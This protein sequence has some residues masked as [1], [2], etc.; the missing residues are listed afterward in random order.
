MKNINKLIISISVSIYMSGCSTITNPLDPNSR[1]YKPNKI[2]QYQTESNLMVREIE[3]LI[4][5]NQY[6]DAAQKLSELS[7][8]G[9]DVKIL[10][11]L[12]DKIKK[13]YLLN[14]LFNELNKEENSTDDEKK[15][16]IIESILKIEPDNERAYKLKKDINTKYTNY[17]VEEPELDLALQARI[18]LEFK[19]APLQ[20]VLEVLSQTSGINF[21]FDKDLNVSS[22]N[23]TIFA[24]NT[25]I[26]EAL[27][28]IIRTG[29]V[30]YKIL[31]NNTFL[32]YDNKDEKKNIY[33]E[34]ITRSFFLNAASADKVQE[35]ITKLYTPKSIFADEKQKLLVVRDKRGVIDSIE[36]LI[37]V[38]DTDTP[39]VLLDI[40]VLEVARDDLLN[41]GVDFP[42]SA[43]LSLVNGSNIL[44]SLTYEQLKNINK[45]NFLLNLSDPLAT[46]NLRET[47]NN[48]NLLANPRI[49]IKS[50]E[51]A[52]FL[53]GDKVPVI[54]TSTGESGRF[55][56]ESISYLDVGLKIDA[57][58]T[59]TPN[60]NID[61][62]I[63]LEV[64]NIV[65]EV[66]SKNGLVAYQIGTRN[67]STKLQLRNGETQMLAG[68]IKEEKQQSANHLPGIGRI[69]FLGRLFSNTTDTKKKSEIV[70]LITPHLVKPFNKPE[71][72][73]L[74]YI[75]GS[76]SE[77][78]S[79]PLRLTN[80]SNYQNS[81]LNLS[82]EKDQVQINNFSSEYGFDLRGSSNLL[83][84]QSSNFILSHG[85][86]NYSKLEI[87]YEIPNEFIVDELNPLGEIISVNLD[88]NIH[89]IS[90][91]PKVNNVSGDILSLKL[92]VPQNLS[93][94][95][96]KF[97]ITKIIIY[98]DNKEEEHEVKFVK[99][100]K[101][102]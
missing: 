19:N 33:D 41:L 36:K 66:Q 54:T 9:V 5:N 18:S 30:N 59:V 78:T 13:S 80:Q 100:F 87:F 22:V 65:K 1:S 25:T 70:L 45:A 10:A 52:N 64:S 71:Y 46:I 35:M 40:E 14:I 57:L 42:N 101:V 29:G 20:S 15:L 26:K 60:N 44:K 92:K 48:S 34:L 38:V 76:I 86:I 94:D 72:E 81:S 69:P 32:I 37:K 99:E 90:V 17:S 23:T 55:L 50:K 89:S 3:D 56:S 79:S 102:E 21:I 31:N 98:N 47:S 83:R 28:L 39:E 16:K 27:D 11:Y 58:P 4:M 96:N 7:S 93:S 85:K 53:I 88:K 8:R 74:K 67:A 51:T 82:K 75:S 91:V 63:K 24:K 2:I 84:G 61:I 68:L 97:K 95:I 12:D 73:N 6:D 77:V 62:D 43:S 49:R